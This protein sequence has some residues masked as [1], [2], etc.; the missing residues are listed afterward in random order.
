MA[1][2]CPEERVSFV[3]KI[4]LSR[5]LLLPI[6][7][8]M[9]VLGSIFTGIASP[10]EA[11]AIGAAGAVVAS[12]IHR[13]FSI[14][15]LKDTLLRTATI[16]CMIMFILFGAFIFA[17]IF[18]QTGGPTLVKEFVLS[19]DVQPIVVILMMQVTYFIL[20]CVVDEITIL[21]IT[22]PIYMPI[23][24]DLGFDPVWFG[25]LFIVNMQ[26]AYLTPPFGYTLFFM[27]G[28][29]PPEVTIVDIYRSI[30]PFIGL[31]WIGVLLVLFFP[32]LA[33]W[34]PNVVFQLK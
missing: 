12:A 9:A 29:A 27:K 17:A 16:N 3:E 22:I 34:L 25:V 26:M 1:P 33:L 14:Q 31:Q 8:I 13:K 11:A 7:L 30:I 20:G 10:T 24:V 32:Q 28:I 19:L 4:K 18:I 21:F 5:G 23:L 6:A 15:L 2:L